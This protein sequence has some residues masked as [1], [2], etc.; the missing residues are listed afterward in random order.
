MDINNFSGGKQMWHVD[1]PIQGCNK[2]QNQCHGPDIKYRKY[3]AWLYKRWSWWCLNGCS[4]CVMHAL[5]RHHDIIYW[6]VRINWKSIGYGVSWQH[7]M[8]R[9][10]AEFNYKILIALNCG[11]TKTTAVKRAFN[12]DR[13]VSSIIELHELFIQDH[14]IN[15]AASSPP[16]PPPSTQF[17]AFQRAL[18][19]HSLL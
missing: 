4:L 11:R 17:Y 14:N 18:L 2:R 1:G 16:P 10:T 9:M 7:C 8:H 15:I 5:Y 6:N 3:G 19:S 12:V 13:S